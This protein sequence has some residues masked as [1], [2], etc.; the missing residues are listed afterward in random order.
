MLGSYLHKRFTE[1]LM[2]QHALVGAVRGLG[3]MLGIELVTDR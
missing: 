3:L 1:E 2:A